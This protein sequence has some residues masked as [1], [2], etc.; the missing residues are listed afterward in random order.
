VE[1]LSRAHGGGSKSVYH[2]GNKNHTVYHVTKAPHHKQE[3]YT[4]KK[5]VKPYRT[6]ATKGYKGTAEQVAENNDAEKGEIYEGES[7]PYEAPLNLDYFDQED[8]LYLYN[9]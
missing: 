6:D 9:L 4:T 2:N 1:Y 7:E 3:P 5:P 8:F